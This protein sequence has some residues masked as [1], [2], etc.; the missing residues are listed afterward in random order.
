MKPHTDVLEQSNV[1][2]NFVSNAYPS[3][4]ISNGTEP[5]DLH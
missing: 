3:Q 4:Q 1:S 5:I 2:V